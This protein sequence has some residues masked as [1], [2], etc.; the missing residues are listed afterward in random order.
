[1]T[2]HEIRE[3]MLILLYISEF[4]EPSE[5]S[6]EAS[7]YFDTFTTYSENNRTKLLE[8][9]NLI[10]SKLPEIDSIIS[11]AVSGWKIDRITKTE[12]ELLRIAIY[13]IK[14]DE[15][16]PGE[17]AINEAVELAKVYGSHESAAAFIN[18]VLAK[19]IN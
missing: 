18:G 16:V 1:M 19:V 7:M 2:R 3:Q 12:L 5:F 4:H 8:R 10:F 11:T 13:E 6:E 9:Y 15:L 14:Y 17:V